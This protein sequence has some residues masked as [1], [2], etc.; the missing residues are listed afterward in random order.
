MS[1]TNFLHALKRNFALLSE[2]NPLTNLKWDSSTVEILQGA[3]H[4]EENS[5]HPQLPG[6]LL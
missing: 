1:S 2:S 5:T 3:A 6:S 4:K